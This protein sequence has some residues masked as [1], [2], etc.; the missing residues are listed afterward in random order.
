M[1]EFGIKGN[2]TIM[3][4][5]EVSKCWYLVII[6]IHVLVFIYLAVALICLGQ[7]HNIGVLSSFL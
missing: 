1:S 7:W 4:L 2:G 3:G 5:P 6:T